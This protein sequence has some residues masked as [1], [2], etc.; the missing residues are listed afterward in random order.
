MALE[1]RPLEKEIP[2]GN[3]D[4]LG[5]MLVLGG[6]SG[7]IVGFFGESLEAWGAIIEN[8]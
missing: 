3:H 5:S 6:V 1:K 4:F 7:V 8:S 2:I